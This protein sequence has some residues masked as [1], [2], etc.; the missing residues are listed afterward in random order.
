MGGGGRARAR[1]AAQSGAAGWWEKRRVD[2]PMNREE[3]RFLHKFGGAGG[4]KARK[5]TRKKA[6]DP[7]KGRVVHVL[8]GAVVGVS[9]MKRPGVRWFIWKMGTLGHSLGPAKK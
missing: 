8:K 5:T 4:K 7:V 9:K 1:W 6:G 2:L 3:E